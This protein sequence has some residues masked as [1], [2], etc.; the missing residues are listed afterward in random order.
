[1]FHGINKVPFRYFVLLSFRY[2]VLFAHSYLHDVLSLGCG[3]RLELTVSCQP[4]PPPP[5]KKKKKNST[6]ILC[7]NCLNVPILCILWF[8]LQLFDKFVNN[9]TGQTEVI[10]NT[11]NAQASFNLIVKC[12]I[13]FSRSLYLY[14]IELK[15]Q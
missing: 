10:C 3:H 15:L 6:V 12:C 2:F 9:Y 8:I 14:L 11:K 7:S 4:P 13:Q 5:Q 1:M